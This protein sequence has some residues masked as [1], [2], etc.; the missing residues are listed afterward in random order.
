LLG[1]TVPPPIAILPP[2][3][4]VVAAAPPL[5]IVSPPSFAFFIAPPVLAFATIGPGWW[6][7]GYV[8]GGFAGVGAGAA[9]AR[10]G[11]TG[12]G[13][14]GMPRGFAGRQATHPQWAGVGHGGR[15]G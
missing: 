10:F 14:A 4:I 8:T 13:F 15:S 7:G 5:I 11:H 9:I 12:P 3:E 6:D 1:A 2:P